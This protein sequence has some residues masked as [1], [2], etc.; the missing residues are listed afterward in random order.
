MYNICIHFV[1]GYIW[2]CTVCAPFD[3]YNISVH[4]NIK[5]QEICAHFLCQFFFHGAHFFGMSTLDAFCMHFMSKS[6]LI[7]SVHIYDAHLGQI[8]LI[9]HKVCT[10][11]RGVQKRFTF[12]HTVHSVHTIRILCV[13]FL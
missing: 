5:I 8:S 4:T 10:N 1:V 12:V 13:H 3:L 7:R 11:V 2:V 9:V 6:V